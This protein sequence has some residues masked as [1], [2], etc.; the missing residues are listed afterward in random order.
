MYVND[1]CYVSYQTWNLYQR[2]SEKIDK[3]VRKSDLDYFVMNVEYSIM[4]RN[5][6]GHL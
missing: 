6:F 3:E 2:Q 1:S 4:L 5:M